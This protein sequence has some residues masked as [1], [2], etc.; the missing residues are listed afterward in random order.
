MVKAHI[1]LDPAEVGVSVRR[2]YCSRRR[3]VR[4]WVT[5]FSSI[6][7]AIRIP[8]IEHVLNFGYAESVDNGVRREDSPTF[9]ALSGILKQFGKRIYPLR[10]IF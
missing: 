9:V 1:T 3:T 5:N 6:Y 10:G 7:K 2:A 4:A 8:F